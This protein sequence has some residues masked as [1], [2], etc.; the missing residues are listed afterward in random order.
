VSLKIVENQKYISIYTE[1]PDRYDNVRL[2]ENEHDYAEWRSV[3][4][5]INPPGGGDR[6]LITIQPGG[7]LLT[8]ILTLVDEVGRLFFII[9]YQGA[10]AYGFMDD[11]RSARMIDVMMCSSVRVIE[12]LSCV[13]FV[14]LFEFAYVGPHVNANTVQFTFSDVDTVEIREEHYLIAEGHDPVVGPKTDVFDLTALVRSGDS[15][16]RC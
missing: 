2:L 3:V 11:P 14:G 15:T 7:S 4:Y 1:D 12:D 8:E 13:L 5:L 16:D 9:C 10:I 6:W